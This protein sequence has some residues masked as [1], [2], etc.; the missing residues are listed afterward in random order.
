MLPPN[1]GFP[2]SNLLNTGPAKS[3]SDSSEE[4]LLEKKVIND[5]SGKKGG[6]SMGPSQ[7]PSIFSEHL[8]CSYQR[9]LFF[10]TQRK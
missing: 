10:S 3:R 9:F 8:T 6:G 4:F 1:L 2:D 5:W 7:A